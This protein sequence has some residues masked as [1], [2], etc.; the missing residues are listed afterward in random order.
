LS[1]ST[2]GDEKRK[3]T[4]NY[5]SRSVNNSGDMRTEYFSGVSAPRALTPE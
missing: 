5:L 2:E 1:E 3:V 4:G